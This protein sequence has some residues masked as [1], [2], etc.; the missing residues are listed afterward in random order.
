MKVVALLSGGLDSTTLV[1]YLIRSKHQVSALGFNY[2]QRHRKELLVAKGIAARIGISY[3]VVDLSPL[4]KL[5]PGSSQTDDSVPVPEGKYDEESMKATVVPN[6]NMIMLSIAIGHAIAHDCEAVAYAAHAGDHAIYPDC[7]PEFVEKMGEAAALCDWKKV[8]IFRPFINMT[9]ADIAGLGVT[10]DGEYH[11]T[12][13]CYAGREKH[14]GK[15][16][17]CIERREAFY[18][19]G[20]NDPTEYEDGT[21]SIE[22]MVANNWHLPR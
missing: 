5:L 12:W 21:P 22:R 17:T 20:V 10:Y 15:C 1:E 2:G 9:K 18:L 13:S 19:A 11:R 3:E 4:A 14:C 16:G 7:R 6:R 8:M